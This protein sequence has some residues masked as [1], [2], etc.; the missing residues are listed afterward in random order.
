MSHSEK[1]EFTLIEL[2]V[3]IAILAILAT[4]LMP[5]VT[6]ARS[7]ATETVCRSNLRQIVMAHLLY[8]QISDGYFCV[9]WD[10][11]FRQW[12]TA[13][14]YRSPGILSEAIAAANSNANEVFECPE[15]RSSLTVRK[16][17][18]SPN[19]AGYGYNYLLSFANPKCYPPNY[20][21]VRENA[22]KNPARVVVA[23]DSACFLSGG[24]KLSPTSFLYNP[25]SGM[26]GY[27][28]FRHHG[29]A[30]A[31]YA[32]GHAE[33]C[34]RIAKRKNASGENANRAGYL[35]EDDSAYSP[36]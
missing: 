17:A 36:F 2:L 1:K 3:V 22:V 11:R 34:R 23:A 18:W 14:D 12:D 32:D 4:L 9:A 25:S 10:E 26:G 29:N 33:S 6:A 19:F 27:A 16:G 28:D 24:E 13:A 15:A 20:R 7:R 30:V 21:G 35:S 8:T 5:A 31:A